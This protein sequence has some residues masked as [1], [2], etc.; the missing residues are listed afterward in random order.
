MRQMPKRFSRKWWRL[1]WSGATDRNVVMRS[2]LLERLKERVGD[3]CHGQDYEILRSTGQLASGISRASHD[4]FF[5]VCHDLRMTR[6]QVHRA[7]W[8]LGIEKAKWLP[9]DYRFSPDQDQS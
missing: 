1:W 6:K 2:L 8:F 7:V 3:Y 9:E 4:L 5:A